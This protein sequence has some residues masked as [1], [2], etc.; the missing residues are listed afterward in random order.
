MPA[1]AQQGRK[2][3][4]RSRG[5][6]PADI[7]QA[8]WVRSTFCNLNGTCIEVSRLQTNR[9]GIRDA[10]DRGNGPVLL[11]TRGEWYAFLGAAKAGQFDN[12]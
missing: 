11:F 12:L 7:G 1:F 2:A 4:L 3:Y 10:K 6:T 8:T 9:I 5:V